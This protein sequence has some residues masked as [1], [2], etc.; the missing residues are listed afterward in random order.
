MTL[1]FTNRT[2][3]DILLKDTLKY[4]AAK[5]PYEKNDNENENENE[6]IYNLKNID[7]DNILP[8]IYEERN[9]EKKNF[10]LKFYNALTR[11]QNS[12]DKYIDNE[13]GYFNEYIN[14]EIIEKTLPQPN[15]KTLIIM[16]GRGKMIKN[17]IYP[18]LEDIGH[19]AE[20]IFKF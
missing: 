6:S 10:K 5:C 8:I 19:S 3:D 18:I 14:R 20:N 7:I 2:E 17:L 4:I 9:V 1:L 16:C 12:Q 13:E 15:E 11:I